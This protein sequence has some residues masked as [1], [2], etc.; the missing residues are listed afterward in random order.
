MNSS[1][2]S[3]VIFNINSNTNCNNHGIKRRQ[4]EDEIEIQMDEDY[5][6]ENTKNPVI[7]SYNPHSQNFYVDTNSL[8]F[9]PNQSYDWQNGNYAK[10]KV[11]DDESHNKMEEDDDGNNMIDDNSDERGAIHNVI[12]HEKLF[13]KLSI[14]LVDDSVIIRKMLTNIL[15][16]EGHNVVDAFDGFNCLDKLKEYRENVGSC[17]DLVLMD[18][19]MPAMDGIE[20]TRQLRQ[21]LQ[22]NQCI[23]ALSAYCD[24][25][26]SIL[27]A[28]ANGFIHKPF[29]LDVLY[30]KMMIARN[31]NGQNFE[32]TK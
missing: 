16:A 20:A 30:Q 11:D 23:I 21:H 14:L 18:I 4:R 28:G 10:R 31:F 6:F 13:K 17:F 32:W 9:Q 2:S 15:K 7:S 25:E 1:S 8:Y 5:I 29:Q 27:M 22:Y 12:K 19:D 3:A 26:E 24:G